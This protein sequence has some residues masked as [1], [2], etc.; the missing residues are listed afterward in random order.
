[1]KILTD[2]ELINIINNLVEEKIEI[3]KE[4]LRFS[5]YEVMIKEKIPERQEN[6]FLQL[7]RTKLNNMGYSVFVHGQEFA[8]NDVKMRVQTNE[9]LIAIKNK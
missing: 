5:F 2:K 7:A 4:F 9:L 1:M 8:Y 6:D 3:N